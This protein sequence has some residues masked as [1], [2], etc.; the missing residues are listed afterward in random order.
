MKP[1]DIV[2]GKENDCLQRQSGNGPQKAPKATS[3][4][5]APPVNKPEAQAVAEKQPSP[6]KHPMDMVSTTCTAT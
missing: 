6:N 1:I 3:P 4:G 5:H 2:A